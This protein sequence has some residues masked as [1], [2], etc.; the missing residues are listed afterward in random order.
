MREDQSGSG[1]SV[2]LVL[3]HSRA[4]STARLAGALVEG[5]LVALQE[6]SP[7]DGG[8]RSSGR[9]PSSVGGP[10]DGDDRS[11][12]SRSG[13]EVDGGHENVG[14]GATGGLGAGGEGDGS[15]GLRVEQ[16]DVADADIDDVMGAAGVV[17]CTPARFGALAGLTKDL[18]ERIYPWFEERPDVR[19]GMA[20][21]AVAKGAT[22]PSGAVRDLERILTGLRWKQ[23]L[24][25]LEVVGDVTDEDLAAASE[26]GATMAAGLVIDIW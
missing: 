20:W 19:P 6:L 5:A 23:V 10:S 12:R 21:T 16:V 14:G 18:L 25:P 1:P 24:A 17:F 3:T 26:L 4:G 8:D 9:G 2:L 7:P 22:D 15:G 13:A 11:R